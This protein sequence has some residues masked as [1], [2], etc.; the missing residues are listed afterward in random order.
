[1]ED[2]GVELL[3]LDSTSSHQFHPDNTLT[4][5]RCVIPQ[6]HV[7]FD[8]AYKYEIGVKSLSFSAKTQSTP[9]LNPAL[10]HC[11][12]LLTHKETGEQRYAEVLSVKGIISNP[13]EMV[14]KMEAESNLYLSAPELSDYVQDGQKIAVY[15]AYMID[16]SPYLAIFNIKQPM[17]LSRELYHHLM[18]RPTYMSQKK[19]LKPVPVRFTPLLDNGYSIKTNAPG[20]HYYIPPVGPDEYHEP[21][22]HDHGETLMLIRDVVPDTPARDPRLPMP[23]RVVLTMDGVDTAV[24]TETALEDTVMMTLCTPEVELG[25][26][27]MYHYEL[28]RPLFHGMRGGEL[29][30]LRFQLLNPEDNTPVP[31]DA[32]QATVVT[33]LARKRKMAHKSFIMRIQS[34]ASNEVYPRNQ[35]SQFTVNLHQ[36]VRLDP[37][38]VYG[39]AV[40]SLYLPGEITPMSVLHNA[41]LVYIDL[42]V[43]TQVPTFPRQYASRRRVNFK[44]LQSYDPD[45]IVDYIQTHLQPGLKR[46]TYSARMDV[47]KRLMLWASYIKPDRRDGGTGGTEGVEFMFSPTLMTVLGRRHFNPGETHLEVGESDFYEDLEHKRQLAFDDPVDAT[48]VMPRTAL[49]HCDVVKTSLTGLDQARLLRV[50]PTEP[51][52]QG[53]VM[54]SLD[55]IPLELYTFKT[56]SFKLTDLHG[57]PLTFDDEHGS[58]DLVLNL[59]VSELQH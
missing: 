49:L 8:Q 9:A 27:Y 58:K 4:H 39:I 26:S 12:L 19:N 40:D 41:D 3:V 2:H 16:R 5:F 47:E 35:P 13:Y 43:F 29:N 30:A 32:A 15:E 24:K 53:Y 21:P 17:V 20:S 59:K 42:H 57:I 22:Y 54:K 11:V 28:E 18:M 25:Y 23:R 52:K 56:L 38:R 14:S 1:M 7:L 34:G 36:E 44:K 45:S 33:L 6:S 31:L 48:R 50:I 55:Y 46:L 37:S 51:H 10:A